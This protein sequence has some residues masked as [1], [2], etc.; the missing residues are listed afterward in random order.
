M[1]E[2]S[3]TSTRMRVRARERGLDRLAVRYGWTDKEMTTIRA[4]LDVR[5]DLIER[6]WQNLAIAR[7]AGFVQSPENGFPTL[8]EWCARTGRR[9]PMLHE[10]DE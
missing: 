2:S 3:R 10:I 9:D 4:L 1:R 6:Y 8:R 7:A 5:P